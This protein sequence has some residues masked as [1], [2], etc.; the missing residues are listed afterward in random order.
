M[1]DEVSRQNTHRLDH[2]GV[3]EAVVEELLLGHNSVLIGIHLGELDLSL[4]MRKFF[5]AIILQ[6]ETL[7]SHPV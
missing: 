6:G 3:V 4:E 2:C 1:R 7:W 5:D